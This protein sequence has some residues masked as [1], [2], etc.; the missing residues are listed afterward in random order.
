MC[1]LCCFVVCCVCGG[2][3]LLVSLIDLFACVAVVCGGCSMFY[4]WFKS[5][6]VYACDCF[7]CVVMF[8]VIVFF[9]WGVINVFIVLL[10]CVLCFGVCC[11]SFR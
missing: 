6:F 1:L 3:L 8:C 7:V 10:R 2:V 11:C 9:C 5:G 4:K